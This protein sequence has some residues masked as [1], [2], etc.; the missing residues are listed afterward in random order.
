MG[1]ELNMPNETVPY[2][3]AAEALAAYTPDTT[4]IW[5]DGHTITHGGG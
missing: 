3:T 2:E 5:V 4:G 1:F